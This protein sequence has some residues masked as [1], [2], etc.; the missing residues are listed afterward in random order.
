V[1]RAKTLKVN[2][3]KGVDSGQRLRVRNEGNAAPKGGQPGDLYVFISVQ[4]D[5]LFRREGVD[6]YT[7]VPCD[8]VPGNRMA[9]SPLWPRLP[10]LPSDRA[11]T[12]PVA[13]GSNLLAIL[14]VLVLPRTTNWRD[15]ALLAAILISPPVIF[16]FERNN[17]DVWM[18]LCLCAVV[19]LASRGGGPRLLAYGLVGFAGLLKFYPFCW[20][21]LCLRERLGKLVAVS[22]A[23]ALVTGG[24]VWTFQAEF[25]RALDNLPAIGPYSRSV[26]WRL[27]V[28]RGLARTACEN[29]GST[30]ISFANFWDFHRSPSASPGLDGGVK[31]TI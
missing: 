31:C 3:P 12:Y 10:F 21:I 23:V 15:A 18:Y 28:A 13:I 29:T 14:S 6:I 26:A 16:A 7:A 27:D 9:Y 5:K 20:M 25:A 2:I 24:G 11:F 8:I 17:I 22:L 19:L 4:D 1:N 30:N